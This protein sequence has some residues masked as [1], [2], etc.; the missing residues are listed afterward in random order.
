MKSGKNIV[1]QRIEIPITFYIDLVQAKRDD[2]RNQPVVVSTQP[3][4][5]VTSIEIPKG[6]RLTTAEQEVLRHLVCGKSNKEIA[7]AIHKCARTVKFH[8]SSLLAKFQLADQRV[9]SRLDIVMLCK[10]K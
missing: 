10:Y 9:R 4:N 3:P 8:I 7:V 2:F 6:I 5:K 1:L